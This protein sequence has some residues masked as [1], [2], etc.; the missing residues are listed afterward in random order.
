M[1]SIQI[2]INQRNKVRREYKKK[3]LYLSDDQR[4]EFRNQVDRLNAEINKFGG[5][6]A[7]RKAKA[8]AKQKGE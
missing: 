1:T 8:E 4:T 7:Y 5:E 6:R 2:L 3:F